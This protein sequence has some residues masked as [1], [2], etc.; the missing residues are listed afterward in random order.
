M[1]TGAKDTVRADVQLRL[2]ELEES[3]QW[4]MNWSFGLLIMRVSKTRSD[5]V[6]EVVS[7]ANQ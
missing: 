5:V 6:L 7:V 1:A 3:T 2:I 4:A